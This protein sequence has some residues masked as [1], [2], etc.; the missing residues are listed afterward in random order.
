MNTIDY[1]LMFLVQNNI[2]SDNEYISSI[3]KSALLSLSKSIQSKKYITKNQS[4][5]IVR[6]LKENLEHFKSNI[7]PD[8]INMLE[9][10]IFEKEFRTIVSVKTVELKFD[11]DNDS[12]MII[13]TV[14][15]ANDALK[16]IQKSPIWFRKSSTLTGSVLTCELTE[17]NIVTV[18]DQLT[19]YQFDISDDLINYYKIICSWNKADAENRYLLTNIKDINFQ[20]HLTNELGK[21]TPVDE[22]IINDRKLR[23]QYNTNHQFPSNSLTEIIANRP[24][25]KI[26]VDK[27]K[28]SLKS[29][30]SSLIILK[31]FPVLV[32]FDLQKE[33]EIVLAMQELSEALD[34]LDIT[35]N[36]G[37]YFRLSNQT[38]GLE[39]NN[40]IFKKQYNSNLDK[41]TLVASVL[42]NKLPKFF[43]NNEWKPMSV[44]SI[45]TSL[46]HSKTAIYANCCDL[47][48]SYTLS[49]PIIETRNM[50][51]YD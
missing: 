17:K 4:N 48:I 34:S 31:R 14:E 19:P 23:Y 6:V 50:W 12:W 16:A 40:L 2:I 46:R 43:I 33:P 38:I 35:S 41:N 22:L 9:D 10:P 11:S 1:L 25:Q 8:L 27:N 24:S 13:V 45:N 37:V 3:D 28:H 15:H 18:V 20:E 21:D 44:I 5:L 26:W 42:T 36:I 30:L 7:T 32:V 49:E 29:L 39:F 47:I 51:E